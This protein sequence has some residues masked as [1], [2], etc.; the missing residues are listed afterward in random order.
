MGKEK[1]ITYAA[2]E[3]LESLM[4]I[5]E[6]RHEAKK[7]LREETGADPLVAI[8]TGKIHS[9]ETRTKYQG[10]TKRFI[11]WCKERRHI[12]RLS[13]ARAHAEELVSAYLMERLALGRKP[14]TLQGDRSGLR[15]FFQDPD[16]AEDVP[17][18][19]RLR[20]EITRSR[21]PA[22]RDQRIS[23]AL[24]E[25]VE[26]FFA[27][28]G[29]RR[30]EADCLRADDVQPSQRPQYQLEIDIKKGYGKGGR[31]RR[32]PV[33]PGREQ[34]VLARIAGLAPNERLFP[35]KVDSRLNPQA[36]R[37]QY[38][39]NFYQLLSGRELP[40]TDRR[41]RKSDYDTAAALEV[42]TYLGHSRIDVILR[43]YLR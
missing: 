39:Q 34:Q 20:Q 28:C 27:A 10:V 15:L 14:A 17:I 33:Y 36:Q 29:V 12:F 2:F 25:P 5:G 16:L 23:R 32:A 3:Q 35:H 18:P 21:K 13:E 24:A 9:Y 26:E 38:A 19:P 31:T 42:S 30:D 40:P 7:A 22:A 37:R 1:G 41:L 6:S 8:S 4:A 11:H 43:S